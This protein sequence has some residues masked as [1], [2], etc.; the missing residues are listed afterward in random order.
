MACLIWPSF[1][2]SEF[3][4]TYIHI[5]HVGHFDIL[6]VWC[7]YQ[8]SITLPPVLFTL[9]LF[10]LRCLFTLPYPILHSLNFQIL[11]RWFI[12]VGSSDVDF[13]VNYGWIPFSHFTRT[14]L[15][16]VVTSQF[17]YYSP[18]ASLLD[19]LSYL[20]FR[21]LFL[22]FFSILIHF[23]YL[24]FIYF[25]VFMFPNFFKCDVSWCDLAR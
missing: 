18:S 3:S 23:L 5:Y 11:F 22:Y 12:L 15:H 4:N 8:I 7:T 14:E 19:L 17:D 1:P 21:N 24:Y 25:F 2:L 13:L 20:L 10:E 6:L 9:P 16:L